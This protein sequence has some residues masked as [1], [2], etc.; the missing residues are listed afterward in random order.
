MRDIP[1]VH[2]KALWSIWVACGGCLRHYYFLLPLQTKQALSEGN[3]GKCWDDKHSGRMQ[4]HTLQ[5]GQSGSV[6]EQQEKG[7]SGC[8]K[9]SKQNI[10]RKRGEKKE[11][12]GWFAG[13]ELRSGCSH[14]DLVR[15][16]HTHKFKR[17]TLM[18]TSGSHSVLSKKSNILPQM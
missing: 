13:M 1:L 3:T 17:H 7:D 8:F 18:S 11:N 6:E 4:E 5:P 12:A 14:K 10:I 9:G 15:N 16:T 2:M